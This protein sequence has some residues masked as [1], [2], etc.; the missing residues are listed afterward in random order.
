MSHAY[1]VGVVALSYFAYDNFNYNRK[2][3]KLNNELTTM[4]KALQ[5]QQ[6][7][8]LNAQKQRSTDEERI[9]KRNPLRWHCTLLY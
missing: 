2:V 5:V 1:F 3:E 8:F 4:E 9:M 7:N 6:A